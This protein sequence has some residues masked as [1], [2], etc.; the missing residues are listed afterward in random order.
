MQTSASVQVPRQ[1]SFEPRISRLGG[2]T[3]GLAKG[4]PPQQWDLDQRTRPLH[5]LAFVIANLRPGRELKLRIGDAATCQETKCDPGRGRMRFQL[6]GDSGEQ[7]ESGGEG[8]HTQGKEGAKTEPA[9]CP[10][11]RILRSQCLFSGQKQFSKGWGW[12]AIWL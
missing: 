10:W 8:R 1:P 7:M 4:T 2:C 6:G 5:A 3:S 11:L 9:S 12:P